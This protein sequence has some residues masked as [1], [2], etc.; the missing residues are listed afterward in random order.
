MKRFLPSLL[1]LLLF[2]AACKNKDYN[3]DLLIKNAVVYTVDSNFSTADAIAIKGGK[4]ISVGKGDTIEHTYLAKEVIDA[5][6]KAVYPGFID[7]HAH[8]YE[9]GLSLQ[10]VRLEN[11]KS[12]QDV[13]D[14]VNTYARRNPEGW[15][16]GRGW[17]QNKWTVKQ[18]PDKAKLDA[19]FPVRPVVLTRIDGHAL[20]ANQAALNIAGIKARPTYS[21]RND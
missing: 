10:E 13:L 19:M 21:R 7:A 6:G 5:G 16:S 1:P 12:W 20:I 4:I 8:F 11:T 15:I 14:S 18:F 9:Y 2:V 17:D 3:A